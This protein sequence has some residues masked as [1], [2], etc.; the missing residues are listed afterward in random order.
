MHRAGLEPATLRLKAGGSAIELSVPR[1]RRVTVVSMHREGFEPPADALEGR[2]SCPVELPVRRQ[3]V[4]HR[5][6][7]AVN[8]SHASFRSYYI[9]PVHPAGVEPATFRLRAGGSAALSYECNS[10]KHNQMQREGLEPSSAGFVDRCS[11]PVELPLRVHRQCAAE[12][13]NLHLSVISGVLR[14]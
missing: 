13:S 12:E 2:C 6:L 1:A 10:I 5:F 8:M 4:P 7:L 14:L 9:Q 3:L 11:S